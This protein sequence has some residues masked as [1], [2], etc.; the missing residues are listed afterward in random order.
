MIPIF[1]TP[2]KS[3]RK[4][5]TK[6]FLEV[7]AQLPLIEDLNSTYIPGRNFFKQ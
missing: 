3:N 2:N 4:S 1:E 6:D 7:K 5:G